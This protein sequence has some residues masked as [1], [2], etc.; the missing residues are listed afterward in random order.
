[1]TFTGR[2][3]S[4]REWGWGGVELELLV[5]AEKWTETVVTYII[6]Y[7]IVIS[8]EQTEGWFYV[9]GVSTYENRMNA[10]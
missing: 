6:L 5:V 2:S 10:T 8:R 9:R 7:C 1:M 4:G 3:L